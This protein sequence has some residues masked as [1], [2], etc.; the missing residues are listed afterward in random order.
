[1]LLGGLVVGLL[2]LVLMGIGWYISVQP[3]L[4]LNGLLFA[5][6]AAPLAA[7]LWFGFA[8]RL[9]ALPDDRIV[10]APFLLQPLGHGDLVLLLKWN[11]AVGANTVRFVRYVAECPV[12]GPEGRIRIAD[13]G[14]EFNGRLVGRCVQSP[15]EHVFSFDH[16][17][18]EGRALRAAELL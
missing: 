14:R 9:I 17:A 3:G 10:L 4:F 18:R 1:V 5:V 11:E 15:K 7:V 8:S 6:T 16:V 13:G 2:P 12:C